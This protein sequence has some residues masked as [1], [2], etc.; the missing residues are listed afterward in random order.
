MGDL[1]AAVVV[2][3]PAPAGLVAPEAVAVSS[4]FPMSVSSLSICGSAC[5]LGDVVC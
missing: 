2:V 3:V 4:T 1:A 5:E